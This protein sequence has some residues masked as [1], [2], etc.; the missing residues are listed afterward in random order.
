[1]A[2]P[3]LLAR[4]RIAVP[5]PSRLAVRANSTA[6]SSSFTP[7]LPAG[8]DP[9]YD[10]AL[11]YLEEQNAA[12]RKHLESLKAKA[13]SSPSAE[14]AER[15]RR[16]EI[17]AWVNDPATRRAFRQT[18]GEGHMDRAVMRHLAE[19]AWRREGELDLLM[20]RVMQLSIV[21]D[22]L[23]DHTPSAAIRIA[24]TESVEPGSIQSSKAFASPP[25]VTVQLFSHPSAPTEATPNPESLYTL[26]IVDPD[27]PNHETQSFSQRVHYAKTDIPL[28]VLSGD[29]NLFTAAGTEL[30]SYEPPA[31]ARGSGKHRYT[32][33]VI[34]QGSTTPS[35]ERENFDL[36]TCL[37]S[38]SL[39]DADAVA[40]SLVR[41]IWT[42]ADA[43]YID[44]TYRAHRGGPAPEYGKSP[45][46]AKY[47]YPLNSMQQR[48]E[49]LR[50]AA[51]GE[52]IAEFQQQ[53]QYPVDEAPKQ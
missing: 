44:E 35:V 14:Q 24:T 21:P 19:R 13:G 6:S 8:A 40:V 53:F 50:E 5:G 7:A 31:P 51:Y 25:K 47:G 27:S 17:D 9:A 20:Q 48:A 33:I 26:L 37:Q 2:T 34:K 28:S 42:E 38:A 52:V 49:A 41:S 45:K 15:I 4:A 30:V 12:V 18:G 22:L 16:L 32:F 43:Q 23:P 46:E 10:V 39:S 1:M 11:A 3:R 29:V 36:R